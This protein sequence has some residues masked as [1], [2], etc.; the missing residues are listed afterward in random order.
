MNQSKKSKHD[1]NTAILILDS[2]F[3]L[4]GELCSWEKEVSYKIFRYN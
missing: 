1:E 3:D 4:T 2:T